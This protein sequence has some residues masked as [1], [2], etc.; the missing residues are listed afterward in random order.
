MARRT[1]PLLAVLRAVH[2]TATGGTWAYQVAQTAGVPDA[3]A[4]RIIARL[5]DSGWA[6]A[7][8]ETPAPTGRP[9]RRLVELTPAGWAGIARVLATDDGTPTIRPPRRRPTTGSTP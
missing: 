6:V 7:R 8:W 3:T 2:A 1:L 5:V 4:T 9:P